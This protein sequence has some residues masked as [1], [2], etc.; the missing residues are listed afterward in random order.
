MQTA[1]IKI[2]DTKAAGETVEQAEEREARCGRVCRSLARYWTH[3]YCMRMCLERDAARK[4]VR[5]YYT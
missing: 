1:D 3:A 5:S 2:A 4:P